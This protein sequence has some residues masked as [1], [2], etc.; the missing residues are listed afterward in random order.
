MLP[1]PGIMLTLLIYARGDAVRI[2]VCGDFGEAGI[3][4]NGP[5]AMPIQRILASLIVVLLT[6]VV[7]LCPLPPGAA[8]AE[9]AGTPQRPGVAVEP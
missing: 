5:Q 4:C 9:S 3:A 6:I 7:F 2:V 1:V 8:Q